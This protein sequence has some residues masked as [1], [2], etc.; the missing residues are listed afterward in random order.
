MLHGMSPHGTITL[1]HANVSCFEDD[2]LK[3]SAAISFRFLLIV[4]TNSKLPARLTAR[5]TIP[6]KVSQSSQFSGRAR[7]SRASSLGRTEDCPALH[8]FRRRF[9]G[10][11]C[12]TPT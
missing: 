12:K 7:H 1:K 10:H 8:S 3:S 9:A 6:G 11:L 4:E 5:F 2:Q